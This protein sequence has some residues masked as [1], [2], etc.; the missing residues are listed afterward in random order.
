MAENPEELAEEAVTTARGSACR[1]P[2]R[3]REISRTLAELLTGDPKKQF[4]TIGFV[5]TYTCDRPGHAQN[6]HAMTGLMT[7]GDTLDPEDVLL[8][9]ARLRELADDTEKQVPVPPVRSPFVR[10]P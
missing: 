3:I 5:G 1:D 7:V 6:R 2:N 8:V 9:V 4:I 10:E